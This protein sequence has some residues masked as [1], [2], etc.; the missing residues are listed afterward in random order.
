MNPKYVQVKPGE[1]IHNRI[2]DES[3]WALKMTGTAGTK[4][5]GKF[6]H[7]DVV[8]GN[9]FI[10]NLRLIFESNDGTIVDEFLHTIVNKTTGK[11]ATT[12][13][14]SNLTIYTNNNTSPE[15]VVRDGKKVS[16]YLNQFF[17][18]NRAKYNM[19]KSLG[20][21]REKHLDYQGAIDIYEKHNMPEEA[22]RVR[23]IMY[24]EK[25]V[26]QTVVHGN[27]VDDRDTIVKDSVINRSN[28]G[29]GSSKMQELKELKEMFDSGFISKDE[30]E[31]MKKEILGK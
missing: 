11:N 28:V 3:N 8:F 25:K 16:D 21:E 23:R 22:A 15:Y 6:V 12:F 9:F 30:M 19:A 14:V 29:G 1:K 20:I 2:I 24:D 27:Y 26:D 7:P 18:S 10:T 31:N 13:S 5:V 4:S 17:Y